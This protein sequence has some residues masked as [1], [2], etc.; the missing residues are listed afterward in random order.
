MYIVWFIGLV[1][2]VFANSPGD[3]CSIPGQV[4]KT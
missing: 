1:G 2:R 3:H 4:L